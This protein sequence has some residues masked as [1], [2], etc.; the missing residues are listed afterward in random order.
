[1]KNKSETSRGIFNWCFFYF[2]LLSTK[3]KALVYII[4]PL[5]ERLLQKFIFI[6]VFLRFDHTLYGYSQIK[7]HRIHFSATMAFTKR[8]KSSVNDNG[9]FSKIWLHFGMNLECDNTIRYFQ[10]NFYFF[11]FCHFTTN[12]KLSISKKMILYFIS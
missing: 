4:K 7:I 11:S 12:L 9:C 8:I 3:S 2:N 5:F 10:P 1:M 6:L